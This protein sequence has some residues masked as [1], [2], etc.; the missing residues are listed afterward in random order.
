MGG[1]RQV[2]EMGGKV[3]RWVAKKGDGWLSS[4]RWVAKLREMGGLV[5]SASV[6]YGSPL[7]S[8]PEISQKYKMGGMSK[9]MADIL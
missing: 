3:E 9:G 2:R 4:G 7:G 8:N 5:G 6:C 1:Y